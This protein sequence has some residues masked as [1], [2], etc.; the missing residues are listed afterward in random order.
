MDGVECGTLNI[1][2]TIKK[3]FCVEDK[4]NARNCGEIIS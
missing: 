2:I 1:Q 3:P 4:G